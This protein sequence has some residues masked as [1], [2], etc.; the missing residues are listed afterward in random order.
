MFIESDP[1]ESYFFSQP[2][3]QS[4]GADAIVRHL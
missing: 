4:T 3:P 2:D 1:I